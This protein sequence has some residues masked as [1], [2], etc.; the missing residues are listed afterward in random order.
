MTRVAVGCYFHS[1]PN[2]GEPWWSR[3]LRVDSG[4][5][6]RA[7]FVLVERTSWMAEGDLVVHVVAEDTVTRC[8]FCYCC[9][10]ARCPDDA[11]IVGH[12]K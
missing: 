10:G 7:G 9:V 5:Y 11:Y 2:R 4:Q 8:Y 12:S 1:I 6:S 3:L